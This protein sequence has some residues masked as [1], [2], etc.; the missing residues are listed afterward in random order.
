MAQAMSAPAPPRRPGSRR[1]RRLERYGS[2]PV[3]D[4]ETLSVDSDRPPLGHPPPGAARSAP[5]GATSLWGSRRC[6]A[7]ARGRPDRSDP[8]VRGTACA[9][10]VRARSSRRRP[11]G[12]RWQAQDVDVD[13]PAV[14][15]AKPLTIGRRDGF[16]QFTIYIFSI[17]PLVA[18]AA[19][20]PLAWGWGLSWLDI[21]LA[22]AFYVISGLGVTVGF[23]RY[24][25]HGSFHANPPCAS[26]WP[27]PAS[28]RCR[29][30]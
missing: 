5:P 11:K 12:V 30:R 16:A 18:V 13:R 4:P 14:A 23:H 29:D 17:V 25:T 2:R 10:H 28:C 9:D 20:V 27:W 21:G 15:T 3:R 26:R 24:F 1:R 6:A 19:A 8:G 7:L 22:A